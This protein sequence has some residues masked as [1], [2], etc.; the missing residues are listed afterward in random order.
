MYV[1]PNGDVL[2][3][4]S[5]APTRA[6]EGKGLKG[7]IFGWA[8][9]RAGA[10]VPSA[11]R[12]TLLRDRNGDGIPETRTVFIKDLNS[13]VGMAL[14][15]DNFYVANTDAVMRFPYREGATSLSGGEKVADLPGGPLNHHWVKNIIPGADG[16]KL[17]A[18]VGSNSNVGENGLDKE[19][20]ARRDPRRSISSPASHA[21]LRRDCAIPTAWRGRAIRCGP[22]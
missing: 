8:Q 10:A 3:A 17:Y 9:K 4:E 2:V 22:W 14:I 21:C 7:V 19:E 5:N 6:E 13:P 16:T 20:N 1:L 15:G 18:S 12:I 11:N